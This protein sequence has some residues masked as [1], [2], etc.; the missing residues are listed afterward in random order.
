VKVTEYMKLIGKPRFG[1][2][3]HIMRDSLSIRL[4]RLNLGFVYG[5]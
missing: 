1:T 5:A 4:F 2:N 3:S